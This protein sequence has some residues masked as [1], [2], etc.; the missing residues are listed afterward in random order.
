MK[1]KVFIDDLLHQVGNLNAVNSNNPHFESYQ[2][3]EHDGEKY[4]VG[5]GNEIAPDSEKSTFDDPELLFSLI[6]LVTESSPGELAIVDK[7]IMNWCKTYGIP[8]LDDLNCDQDEVS[9]AG[10]GN[11]NMLH[12]Q[13]FK[14]SVKNLYKKFRLWMALV[15]ENENEI[16]AFSNSVDH[17]IERSHSTQEKVDLLKKALAKAINIESSIEFK[18]DYNFDTK[19]F[20]FRLSDSCL[21]SLAYYQFSALLTK[22]DSESKKKMKQCTYC[23]SIY[24]AK[25][26]NAKYCTKCNRRTIW[27]RKNKKR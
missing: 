10:T 11:C 18:L 22:D 24:W 25:H 20:E 13:I 6:S 7:N 15:N 26:A 16:A 23:Q 4:I 14:Y 19:S 12:V 9:R 5:V 2:M 17:F 3:Q 21:F 8:Y 27:S 1:N